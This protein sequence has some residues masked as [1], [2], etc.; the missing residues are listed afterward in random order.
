MIESKAAHFARLGRAAAQPLAAAEMRIALITGQMWLDA[1][2]LSADQRA[3]LAAAAAPGME[4]VSNGFPFDPYDTAPFRPRPLLAA[5]LANAR[6]YIWART[7]W[8]YAGLAASVLQ[9]LLGSTRRVLVLVA[10]SCGLAITAAASPFLR[11]PPGLTVRLL[12]FGPAGLPPRGL[13][14]TSVCGTRDLWS[15]AFYRGPREP[16]ISCG[17]LEYWKSCEARAIAASF[18]QAAV[19]A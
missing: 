16:P 19:S 14:I 11:I 13:E 3:F 1:S 10:G 4:M 5:S 8:R 12:A 2:P 7:D 18:T 9:R 15:R 17:H 6:Q